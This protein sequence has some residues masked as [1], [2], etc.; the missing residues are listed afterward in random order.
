[1][2]GESQSKSESLWVSIRKSLPQSDKSQLLGNTA[3]RVLREDPVYFSIYA[4]R[5]KFV[6][7]MLNSSENVIEVGCGDG[8]GSLFLAKTAKSVVCID[9]D[10][11]TLVD[12]RDRLGEISNL[13]FIYHDFVKAPLESH[14]AS[15]DTLVLVD[16]LEH[17][18]P[19]E[20]DSF[21]RNTASVLVDNG[22]AIFGTPNIEALRFT[23][24]VSR[25]AHVNLKS[26]ASLGKAIGRYYERV[27]LFGQNDEVLHTGFH[28]MSHYL[29]AIGFGP[30]LAK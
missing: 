9:I 4:A 30:K 2:S 6:S 18:E 28:G 8:F 23:S 25:A 22:I 5:Y 11:E 13:S 15:A 1:M 24:E 19:N 12:C 21:L 16:V 3:R 27:L 10:H 7:R 17:I 20:E 14:K 26:Q 29:W